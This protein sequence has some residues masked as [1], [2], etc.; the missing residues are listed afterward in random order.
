MENGHGFASVSI[1]PMAKT[2]K[3]VCHFTMMH[4]GEEPH[5][6]MYTNVNVSETVFIFSSIFV[7]SKFFFLFLLN[8]HISVQCIECNL[9]SNI[10][11]H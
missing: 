2:V 9:V 5:Q 4:H 8:I 10:P 6:K 1:S 3:S 7:L 11:K